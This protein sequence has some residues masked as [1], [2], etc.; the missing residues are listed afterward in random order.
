MLLIQR[1]VGLRNLPVTQTH[2]GTHTLRVYVVND[3]TL[4]S[5]ADAL[6]LLTPSVLPF[7]L[8]RQENL[9]GQ[10][11][12]GLALEPKTQVVK[13]W[14]N[15]LLQV[16]SSSSS[17]SGP[18]PITFQIPKNDIKRAL[19]MIKCLLNNRWKLSMSL[20]KNNFTFDSWWSDG[21][22]DLSRPRQ[23]LLAG[24]SAWLSAWAG[25]LWDQTGSGTN[26]G[27][28]HRDGQS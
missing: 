4:Q 17:L 22:P 14:P 27:F 7:E 1:S 13:T 5:A 8:H 6:L 12:W 2:N 19:L 15:D 28:L 23:Q 20:E 10:G 11:R 25:L 3:G 9:T 24:P 18:F 21:P 16:G 26:P